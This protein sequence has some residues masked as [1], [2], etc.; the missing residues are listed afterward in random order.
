VNEKT[1]F[2]TGEPG[3]IS[4]QAMAQVSGLAALERHTHLLVHS[5]YGPWFSLRSVLIFDSLCW[6][7]ALPAMP[8]HFDLPSSARK[9]VEALLDEVKAGLQLLSQ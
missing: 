1:S 5:E 9:Q 6:H 2:L 4:A 8:T 3:W 7:A